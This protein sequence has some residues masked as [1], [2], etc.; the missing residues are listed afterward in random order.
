MM[1]YT[2]GFGVGLTVTGTATTVPGTVTT[3]PGTVTPATAPP[4]AVAPVATVGATPP[5]AV[6]APA[7]S[8]AFTGAAT[9]AA[10]ILALV[11]IGIGLVVTAVAR[12]CRFARIAA[13]ASPHEVPTPSTW[14]VTA[15]S[16]RSSRT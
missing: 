12:R 4:G 1:F 5:V 2:S 16:G 13:G 7:H 3:V 11:L 6:P 9:L 10:V 15:P 14:D 8:L